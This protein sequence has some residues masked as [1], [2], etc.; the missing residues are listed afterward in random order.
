MLGQEISLPIV[1]APLAFQRI[2]HAEGEIA[3]ARAARA[4]G[5]IM[6]LSTNTTVPS[7]EVAA[8]DP[9]RWFQ[10]YAFEDEGLTRDLVAQARDGGSRRSC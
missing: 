1:V 9:L 5:T 6:C 10:L 4:V 3:M 8:V 2:G 7:A